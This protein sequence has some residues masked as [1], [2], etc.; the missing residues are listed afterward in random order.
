[1]TSPGFLLKLQRSGVATL[2]VPT[3][4]ALRRSSALDN[5]AHTVDG[6]PPVG[7]GTPMCASLIGLQALQTRNF[8]YSNCYL[9]R[10]GTL[11]G[12]Y[13]DPPAPAATDQADGR[14]LV[15]LRALDLRT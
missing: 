6:T 4:R 1:M 7:S 5:H 3:A 15:G 2:D 12:A 13:R 10:N 11:S 8:S 14:A 9:K